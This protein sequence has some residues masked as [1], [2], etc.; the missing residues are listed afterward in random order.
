MPLSKLTAA[1]LADRGYSVNMAMVRMTVVGES[2]GGGELRLLSGPARQLLP[3]GSPPCCSEFF[4]SFFAL[5]DNALACKRVNTKR[6]LEHAVT[7]L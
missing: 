7:D 5:R 4:F 3:Q 6:R 2:F 1:T